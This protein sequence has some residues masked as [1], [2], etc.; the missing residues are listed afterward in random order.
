MG[1]DL[2]LH[3]EVKIN[4]K[5][6]HYGS[7]RPHRNY[8]LFAKMAN[9]RNYDEEIEPISLPKGLPEDITELT[10]YDAELLGED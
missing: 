9:V 1:C 4:G 6:H 3:T 2:H 10:K 8:D 5:L 7:H